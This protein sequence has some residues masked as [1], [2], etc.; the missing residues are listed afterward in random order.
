MSTK[1]QM[2]SELA[3]KA[4]KE[5]THSVN[6]WCLFLKSQAKL[7]KY[8]YADQLMIYAQRSDAS[9][10]LTFDDWT[11]TMNRYIHKGAKGIGLVDYSGDAPKMKYVFDISDTSERHN[12]RAI[13]IWKC[14]PDAEND[15]IEALGSFYG[16]DRTE[17]LDEML[18][19][20]CRREARQYCQN[21]MRDFNYIV[22][23]SFLEDYDNDNRYK[24]LYTLARNS[25]TYVAM[26]RCDINPESWLSPE[27]FM[28]VFDFNTPDVINFLGSCV[29]ECSENVLRLVERA[30]KQYERSHNN[31]LQREGRTDVSRT[32]PEQSGETES[33]EVRTDEE[34]VPENKEEMAV[35]Q[36]DSEGTAEL[37]SERDSAEGRAD[38]E[39]GSAGD[40]DY[41][42]DNQQL[43]LFG[44]PFGDAYDE[45]A[46]SKLHKLL[47][48]ST[49]INDKSVNSVLSLCDNTE[50]AR[51][52]IA[53][54]F[55]K[56]KPLDKKIDYL[57]QIYHGGCGLKTDDGTMSAFFD[58][59]GMH[60]NGGAK[61][62]APGSKLLTWEWVADR[63]TDLLEKGE[64]TTDTELRDAPFLERKQIA[65]SVWYFE[66]DLTEE[67]SKYFT[68]FSML[69]EYKGFPDEVVDLSEALQDERYVKTLVNEMKAFSEAYAKDKD[70]LRFN[71][72]KVDVLTERISD[73]L[74]PR[75]EWVSS[76]EG[77]DM[78]M[79]GTF[80]TEDEID[81]TL[82]G[83][84][85]VSQGK[86]RIAEFFENNK[87]NKARADFLKNE[88][89]TGGRSHAVSGA[90][91]SGES[92]DAK[93]VILTKGKASSVRLSWNDV[94]KKIE[95]LIKSDRY[96]NEKEKAELE[97]MKSAPEI[98]ADK[99]E[100]ILDAMRASGYE[101]NEIDSYDDYLVFNGEG[102]MATF[103]SWNEAEDWLEGVVLD[104][105]Q[106]SFK[107][108]RIMHPE[109]FYVMEES[110]KD[111]YCE[112]YPD[113]E[114][115][116]K[117]NAD[118]K[119]SE[120]VTELQNGDNIYESIGVGDSVVRE[121]IFTEL[122]DRMSVSYDEIYIMWLG[123]DKPKDLQIENL[124]KNPLNRYNAVKEHYPEHI[125]FIQVGEFYEAFGEDAKKVADALDLVLT[126][127]LMEGTDT[128]IPMCGF[129]L[130]NQDMYF[131]KLADNG[132]VPLA[133]ARNMAEKVEVYNT[134]KNWDKIPEDA[135]ARAKP[136]VLAKLEANKEKVRQNSTKKN[137]S[138]E[139][140]L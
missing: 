84:S 44:Q 53:A 15:V 102:T 34:E 108:E 57:K 20:V 17:N 50:N 27:D 63:V 107:V 86:L 11:Q 113:D 125:C 8:S 18:F 136:S 28:G 75:K 111:W 40:G 9:L 97:Q 110:V 19:K 70:L 49:V 87:E 96:L 78:D 99:K 36:L 51:L 138:K 126:G 5:L 120:V 121:R 69:N 71:F 38:A 47:S 109:R 98:S 77:R 16:I 66:R 90:N 124:P 132:L 105:D 73:L 37:A 67:G 133:V 22:D 134:A 116:E 76:L 54:E 135:I 14:N 30:E 106:I 72:H 55:S 74:I 123:N 4:S 6:E 68:C 122:S 39:I 81:Q 48:A 31:D 80:I 104:D 82:C 58:N 89:G 100:M 42:E 129:P 62:L 112:R 119:F 85:G 21:F 65:E 92:H 88:Y 29:S 139:I 60:I 24:A 93:G 140:S 41:S 56:E 83:G 33:R 103:K 64:F 45:E 79:Y 128:R 32:E 13:N 59:E 1:T 10:C 117:I 12:S 114:L 61:A 25:I 131:Q 3:E 43:N 26:E 130:H 94:S 118:L 115:G 137:K 35:E 52:M 46:E 127:R 23:D 95:A 91:H 2:Y 101:F 7:Y